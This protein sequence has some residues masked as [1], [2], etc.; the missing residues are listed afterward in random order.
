MV[1]AGITSCS[2][3]HCF[4]ATST[5]KEVRPVRLPPGRFRL[6]T[7]PSRTGS[8]ATSKMIGMVVVAALAARAAGAPVSAIAIT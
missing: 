8:S 2:N 4:G 7:S 5:F 6:A 3:A 1:A